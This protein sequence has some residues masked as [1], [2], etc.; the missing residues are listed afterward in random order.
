MA[1]RS[2]HSG[3][4]VRDTQTELREDSTMDGFRN[5]VLATGSTFT[6][7]GAW[8]GHTGSAPTPF[9]NVDGFRLAGPDGSHP[10][11]ALSIEEMLRVRSD[12]LHGIIEIKHP[13][14]IGEAIEG[15]IQLTALHEINARGAMLRLVGAAIAEHEESK[16][17]RD[18][19]G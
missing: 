3:Q 9:D 6:G 13:V 11:A 16:E 17:N 14:R 12:G 8:S 18:S 1:A 15:R 7:I 2:E 5:A 10:L 4:T 19:E